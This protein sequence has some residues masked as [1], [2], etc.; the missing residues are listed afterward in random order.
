MS[1]ASFFA[2]L[3]GLQT[4]SARLSV[5]GN[6]LANVNTVGYKGSR[7][8]FMDIFSAT[9][10]VQFS[11]AGNPMQIGRGVQFSGIDQIFSQGSLQSTSLLTDISIQ[12]S[13]FFVLAD[14]AGGPSYTRAGNFTFDESGNLISGSGRFVQGFTGRDAQ[15]RILSSGAI[16]NITIPS[17]LSAQPAPTTN[18]RLYLNLDRDAEP[19]TDEFITTLSVFDSVGA[20]HNVTLTFVP[21][22]TDGN[23][24]HDQWD[25]EATVPGDEV[26]GGTAG[27]DFVIDSGT[28][29]FGADGQ[30]ASPAANITLS[31]AG[32]T[33]G[34]AAQNIDWEL[35]DDAGDGVISSWSGPSA[36][37]STTQDGYGLGILRT[38]VIE[39][40]GLISGV[41]TNG[42]TRDLA[43]LAVASFN[44]LNGLLRDGQNTFLATNSAGPPTIGA[45]NSGGRGSTTSN[46]LEL[47]NVDITQEF[48]DMI[49]TQRGYQ[50]NSRIIT[51]TD[52]V[53]QEAL[54][55]KR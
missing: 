37:S 44:N 33:N 32:W 52:E 2:G 30:L 38:L 36:V 54:S 10:G 39:E 16:G 28:L 24:T 34:A 9:G 27:T 55:L 13:G 6:N 4:N 46:T 48:T 53:I 42:V 22:D 1:F 19:V 20:R 26:V 3:T 50:A 23:G 7:A 47:S 14:E 8:T 31:V 35:Y 41:F 18:M 11:G 45:A 51:T 40:D 12:G 15:D 21:V 17:G 25:W 29:V 49:I 5:I 43:R